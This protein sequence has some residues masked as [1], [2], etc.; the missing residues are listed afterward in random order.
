MHCSTAGTPAFVAGIL[1]MRFGR[2]TARQR[3]F[4]SR[5]VPSVSCARAGATSMLTKPSC[6]RLCLCSGA[7]RSA[8]AWMSSIIRVDA[9]ASAPRPCRAR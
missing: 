7:N 3:R 8:A 6:P 2:R 9:I 1:T 5:T 4:A